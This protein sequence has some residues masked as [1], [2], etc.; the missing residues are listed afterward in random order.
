MEESGASNLFLNIGGI[1]PSSY[2]G[3]EPVKIPQDP[4]NPFIQSEGW[5][6]FST[7]PDYFEVMTATGKKCADEFEEFFDQAKG[8]LF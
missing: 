6:E 8:L 4:T 7:V 1:S 3:P 2:L 5:Y